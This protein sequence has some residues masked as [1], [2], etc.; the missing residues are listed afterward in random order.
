MYEYLTH[1]RLVHNAQTLISLMIIYLVLSGWNSA[2]ELHRD[3]ARF[4]EMVRKAGQTVE[5]P[6][7]LDDLVPEIP[8]YRTTLYRELYDALG[9]V[10]IVYRDSL[11]IQLLTHFPEESAPIHIQWQEL[12]NQQWRV[13]TRLAAPKDV[14]E[15]VRVWLERWRRCQ[16]ALYRHLAE[17]PRDEVRRYTT[18]RLLLAFSTPRNP[19]FVPVIIQ[20]AVYSPGPRRHLCRDN[21]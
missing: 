2:T 17:L 19:D 3:L 18:P 21:K 7:N 5:R 12:Q 8:D 4:V 6:E 15:D 16:P 14:L 10:V 13:P 11:P 20:V 1:M 9:R